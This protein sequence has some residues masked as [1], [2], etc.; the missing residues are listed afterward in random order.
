MREPNIPAR[1]Q[2]VR[3]SSR[4]ADRKER[5]VAVWLWNL[6]AWRP[7]DKVLHVTSKVA[8]TCNTLPEKTELGKFLR[9]FLG[10]EKL[11]NISFDFNMLSV[12]TIYMTDSVFAGKMLTTMIK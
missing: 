8:I 1:R 6:L 7:P 12:G 2:A 3:S 5:Q 9:P 11:V 10:L 4:A